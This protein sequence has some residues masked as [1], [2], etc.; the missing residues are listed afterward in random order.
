[1]KNLFL[2][3]PRLWISFIA[4]TALFFFLPQRLVYFE[5]RAGV[6]EL[7]RCFIPR[8]DFI[9]DDAPHSRADLHEVHRRG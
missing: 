4:G 7:R 2:G 3:H 5:P 8:T 9:L 6:L 1:M